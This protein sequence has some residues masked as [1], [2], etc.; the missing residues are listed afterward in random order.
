MMRR[1]GRLLNY[2][3]GIL[4]QRRPGVT[5]GKNSRVVWSR[6]KLPRG[7]HFSIGKNS[8]VQCRVSFDSSEGQITIGDRC[9]IGLSHLVCRSKIEIANDVV[10]SWGATI[11]DH[12]S[13]SLSWEQRK[14]DVADWA[15]GVKN[16]NDVRHAPVRI[17]PKVWIGFNAIILKGVTIGEGAVVGAGAV[18][19]KDVPAWTIVAGNPARAIRELVPSERN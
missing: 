7:A 10:M 18:V 17:E 14:D 15:R 13:H 11:V 19:S 8:I 16:W 5:A 3:L 9:Y 4:A 12:N 6:I 2:G 1:L